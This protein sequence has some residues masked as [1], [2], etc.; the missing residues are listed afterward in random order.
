MEPI[1]GKTEIVDPAYR[2]KMHRLILKK[3]KNKSCITNLHEIVMD[4]KIP[5]QEL[6]VSFFKKRLSLSITGKGDRVLITSDVSQ[7]TLQN[8]LYEFIEYFVI[9]KRCRLPELSYMLTKNKL[10]TCC[11]SCGYDG[12]IDENHYTIKI[13]KDFETILSSQKMNTKIGKIVKD[14][15]EKNVT[16]EED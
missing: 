10:G 16:G 8:T 13:I 5:N 11:C 15:L 9:C 4:I 12:T 2:Y 14:S 1:R 7:Q 3:E 6:I